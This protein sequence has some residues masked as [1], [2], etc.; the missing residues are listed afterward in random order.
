MRVIAGNRQTVQTDNIDILINIDTL[1]VRPGQHIYRVARA[2]QGYRAVNSARNRV[3]HIPCPR[4]AVV[5]TR[6]VRAPPRRVINTVGD[7]VA[8]PVGVGRVSRPGRRTP[9]VLLGVD[10]FRD[11][12]VYRVTRVTAQRATRH[13]NIGRAVAGR[14]LFNAYT[15]VQAGYRV[16]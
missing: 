6:I 1:I 14:V 12:A 5:I 11:V 15:P 3:V 9:P 8:R 16:T 4:R 10:R 2:R 13:Y 7:R